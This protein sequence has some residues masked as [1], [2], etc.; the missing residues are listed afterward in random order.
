MEEPV[1]PNGNLPLAA[2]ATTTPC[3]W[4]MA[5]Q[6]V[7]DVLEKEARGRQRLG[8]VAV[9]PVGRTIHGADDRKRRRD[10]LDDGDGDQGT[11][12]RQVHHRLVHQP[13]G[14][15]VVRSRNMQ[16]E[17]AL[18]VLVPR[19]AD[20]AMGRS[21]PGV[22][23]DLARCMRAGWLAGVM[24]ARTMAALRGPLRLMPHR[25]AE[26]L[27]ATDACEP[28]HQQEDPDEKFDRK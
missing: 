13:H 18:G 3:V 16:V 19:G 9:G 2:R 15:R 14:R 7:R 25:D 26:R 24:L 17:L 12:E 23:A 28:L 27:P 4:A 10:P 5:P 8:L 11:E 20:A 21:V 6:S 1:Q 22:A